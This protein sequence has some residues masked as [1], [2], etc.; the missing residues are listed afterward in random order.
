VSDI[1]QAPDWW[2]ASD[3]KWYPPQ[4][5][6]PTQD[7][8]TQMQ[9]GTSV[10]PGTPAA[11]PFANMGMGYDPTRAGRGCMSLGM[12][13]TIV[14]LLIG[15]A[16]TAVVLFAVKD[17]SDTID[18]TFDT[19]N[20][21]IDSV[22]VTDCGRDE[23]SFNWGTSTLDVTNDTDHTSTY[24][25]TVTFENAAGSRQ[26]GTG[27]AT[28]TSLAP[29]RT[30]TVEASSTVEVPAQVTCTVTDVNRISS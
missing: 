16:I 13:I 6:Q 26:F 12:I 1:P 27:N 18:E 20:E 25:I 19:D 15:A 17:A 11:P 22:E 21:A 9:Q 23:S 4:A 10:P 14:T 3:G 30:T 28:V 29:G 5:G 2:Q 7:P 24:F 8:F